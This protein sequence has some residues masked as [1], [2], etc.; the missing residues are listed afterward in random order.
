MYIQ[1]HNDAMTVKKEAMNLKGGE[2]YGRNW[3]E[4]VIFFIISKL[5]K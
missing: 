4:N 5:K 1:I 2:V 3:R